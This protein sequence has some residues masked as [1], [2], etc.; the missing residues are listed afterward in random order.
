MNQARCREA[1]SKHEGINEGTFNDTVNYSAFS[2]WTSPVCDGSHRLGMK[3]TVKSRPLKII[4]KSVIEKNE[5][6]SRLGR[7]KDA[8]AEFKKI[9]ITDDYT[10]EE[11]EEIKRWIML[12]KE[13]NIKEETGYTWKVRGTPKE[14]LRLALI[15]H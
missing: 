5:V 12:A 2:D 6:M 8:V 15:K 14:G 10:R 11:R 7:L 9:S 13:K 3:H 4:M 1:G